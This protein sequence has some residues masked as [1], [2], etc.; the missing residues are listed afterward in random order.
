ML[1]SCQNP[2]QEQ[3]NTQR[4]G[5]EKASGKSIVSENAKYRDSIYSCEC[6]HYASRLEEIPNTDTNAYRI[7]ITSKETQRKFSK[8]LDIRPEMSKINYCND[9]YTVVG[10][11]CGGPCY[12]QVYIFTDSNRHTE[13]YTYAQE[14][15]NNPNIIGHIRDEKF[16]KLII[17][18]FSN[19]KELEVD[20]S[21]MNYWN[22]GQVDSMT[23]EKDRLLLYYQSKNEKQKKKSVT[24]KSI[25]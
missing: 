9:L 1:S 5:K 12:S 4:V 15:K 25:L 8:L 17:H 6:D 16:E 23:M 22:A 20:I 10:F 11:P 14:V 3:R 19:G 24:I 13:Q 18:N 7:T 21:D 2:K